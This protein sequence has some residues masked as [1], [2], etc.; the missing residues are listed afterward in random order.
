MLIK[1][2]LR[3]KITYETVTPKSFSKTDL[4]ELHRQRVRA[5]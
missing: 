4:L 1:R 3:K 2:V 5:P